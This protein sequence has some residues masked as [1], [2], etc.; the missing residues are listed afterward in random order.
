MLR[1]FPDV[2]DDGSPKSR[3]PSSRMTSTAPCRYGR[4]FCH[5]ASRVGQSR[6]SKSSARHPLE[7][8]ATLGCQVSSRATEI[9]TSVSLLRRVVSIE[10][11]RRFHRVRISC[12]TMEGSAECRSAAV[13]KISGRCSGRHRAPTG[14][15]DDGVPVVGADAG[16]AG[17]KGPSTGRPMHA[18]ELA[19]SWARHVLGDSG[20]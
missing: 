6:R 15:G 11:C 9:D 16:V 20:G 17:G 13:S 10:S 3:T 18:R 8:V 19:R 5:C 14:R 7:L 1:R 4:S 2:A 12:Q